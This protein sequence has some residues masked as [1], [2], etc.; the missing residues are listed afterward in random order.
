MMT[1]M[2]VRA[3]HINKWAMYDVGLVDEIPT[4]ND[5]LAM[6]PADQLQAIDA[7]YFVPVTDGYGA[8]VAATLG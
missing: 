6:I 4:I 1:R 2:F 3:R 5:A 8:E 7:F